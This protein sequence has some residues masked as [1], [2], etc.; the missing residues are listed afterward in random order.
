MIKYKY[1]CMYDYS[2]MYVKNTLNT[3]NFYFKITKKI[4]KFDG[5]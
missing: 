4:S 1:H 2:F 3:F 5:P